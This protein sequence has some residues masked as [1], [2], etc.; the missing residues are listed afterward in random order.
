MDRLTY[1]IEA[2]VNEAV[3]YVEKQFDGAVNSTC[4]YRGDP[5]PEVD[6][7]W[8]RISTDGEVSFSVDVVHCFD[9]ADKSKLLG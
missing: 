2:P 6:A 8:K 4:V 5:S 1:D 3:R 7:A 9:Q